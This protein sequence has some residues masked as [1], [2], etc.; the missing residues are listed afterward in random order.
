MQKNFTGKLKFLTIMKICATQ[1]M[2]AMVLCG[3]SS[4][5]DNYSQLLSRPVTVN[6]ETVTLENALNEIG[7]TI[8]VKFFYSI[9]RLEMDQPVTVKAS[10]QP[11]GSVLDQL[12]RPFQIG[13]KVY[14]LESAIFLKR[15]DTKSNKHS[16]DNSIGQLDKGLPGFVTG[17]V[18][19]AKSH[20]P[21]PGVNIVIKGTTNGT[22]TDS[23]GH[24]RIQAESSDHLVFS[25]VG[26]QSQEIAVNAQTVIDVDLVE[27]TTPLNEVVVN[28]GYWEVRDRDRTG[29]ISRITANEI[30]RQP[31]SNPIAAL[32]GRIPGLDITQQTGVPGGNFKV[33]I[34]GTNSIANGNDPLYII[35]GVPFNSTSLSF[36]ETSGSILGSPNPA[37]GQ[38]TSP[39]N[40]INP[41]DIES[42]EVLKDADATAIYGSRGSN[43]VILITTKKG[44]SGKTKIDFRA[45]QGVGK[46]ARKMDLL[47]TQQYL[48]MRREAFA[49]DK[50]KPSLLNARD[51]L[52][53][54]TTRYTDWQKVLIGGTAQITDGQLSI[55]GGD[56]NTRFSWGGGYHRETSVFPGDNSDR[57]ISSH[58]SLTNVS[59]NKKLK[60]FASINYA[61]NQTNLLKED[62]TRRA[63]SLPPIA[64][65]LYD[66]LGNVS[67]TNWSSS[68]ENP[69]AFLKREYEAN[70]K[71]LI[72][73]STIA[74]SLLPN[75]EIKSSLGYTDTGMNAITTTPISSLDP[76]IASSQQNQSSFSNSSFRN[77]IV[78]PQANWKPALSTGQFDVMVGTT[79]LN[80]T[81]EGLAQ[82]ATGFSSEALMKNLAAASARTM[83]TNYYSNYRYQAVFGR[84]NYK[85][86]DKYIINLTGRRDG[87]SRFG[88]GKQFA[89]FG[90]IGAAWIWSEEKFIKNA[91]SFLSLGKLRLSYGVTGNDQLGD[92]QYL[93][94][95]TSSSG[96]YQGNIGLKPVR[97]S[98]PN[99]AWE[100][101]RKFEAGL[102]LAFFENRISSTFSLYVNRSSN[103]L[104]GFPLP[105]TTGFPSIQGNFPAEVQNKGIELLIRSTNIQTGGLTW[106]TMANLTIPRNQLIAFPNLE[107]SSAYSNTYVVGKPLS[108][109]KLYNNGG[110]DPLKGTYVFTDV[111]TD[112]V[113]DSKDRQNVTFVGQKLYGGLLNNLKYKGFEFDILFQFVSQSGINYRL[114]F[115]TAPG[116]LTNQPDFVDSRWKKDGDIVDIQKFG[117][118]SVTQ[119]P[120]ANA[121]NSNLVV[122]DASFV[123]LKN[124]SLSYTFPRFKKSATEGPKIFVIGQNLLTI[125]RYQGLDPETQTSFLPPLKTL[126]FGIQATF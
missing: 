21:M 39:L 23:E 111:N 62:L 19:D 71:N 94:T 92:Y 31:V 61:V 37:I 53:W 108:I 24:F 26:F 33:R 84:V 3:V 122:T 66:E 42:I 34:R 32:Q 120:Y 17:R 51:L 76:K 78:E 8:S 97:L 59:P 107:N 1:G 82:T 73:N 103:Q 99:F 85:F 5:H 86:A 11:L 119:S 13:Y 77:W 80:Q 45:Y 43:G 7:K 29:N 57:R 52:V 123:R 50:I 118:T 93:D 27:E 63:L 10:G 69:L 91:L 49:N 47:G 102:E 83:G 74:Y 41:S 75:L 105:P 38:G 18:N 40:S 70:T 55:S 114:I 65:A 124:A 15:A 54:D 67:W 22:N 25:F 90:A 113:L 20:Q 109:R 117:T 16:N 28:A 110:V 58:V 48:E 88:P 44:Q 9:D 6:I 106:S 121:T 81:R 56:Q 2:I 79:F 116:G 104:V 60:V 101:N 100:T 115:D 87:S 68:Y 98:N 95:Y 30:Q 64:P 36:A 112:G 46:V 12:L 4:A 96:S 72:G 35:D 89:N 14:E 125:T 126:S